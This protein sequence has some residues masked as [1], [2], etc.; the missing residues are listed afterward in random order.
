[1]LKFLREK[2]QAFGMRVVGVEGL[3]GQVWEEG[4]EVQKEASGL[5]TVT[6]SCPH[7]G[8]WSCVSLTSLELTPEHCYW[9]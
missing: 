2:K 1:M 4:R 6:H 5:G 7:P 8:A 9:P 3:E